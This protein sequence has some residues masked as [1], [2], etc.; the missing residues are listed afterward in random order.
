MITVRTWAA[1]MIAALLASACGQPAFHYVRDKG[2]TT[3]F[4]VPSS[5]A[6]LDAY[7][8]ELYLSRL[9]PDSEA[10]R[11]R[12]ERVWSTAFDRA[13]APT[14]QHLLSSGDPFVYSAV[15]QL[16]V[17]ERDRVSLDGLRDFVFPVTEPARTA[18]VTDRLGNGQM[19]LYVRFEPLLDRVLTLDGGA[20][21]VRLRFNYQIGPDVQTFDQTAILDERGSTVSVLIVSC[22]SLCFRERGG[23]IDQIARSFKLLRL[24]G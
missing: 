7:P 19:P 12:K 11:L 16:T 9:H 3:Y 10:A 21:G 6:Q 24:P 18:Y 22:R 4:K 8:I 23:E 13:G 1:V 14:L 20:R 5:F 2:G 17:R 15:H